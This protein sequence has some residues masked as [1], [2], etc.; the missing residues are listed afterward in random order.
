MSNYN[1]NADRSS[2]NEP[3]AQKEQEQ[4]QAGK[5]ANPSQQKDYTKQNDYSRKNEQNRSD[6]APQGRM[7]DSEVSEVEETEVEEEDTDQE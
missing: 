2:A 5:T 3:K 4:G 1:K 6:K 7:A